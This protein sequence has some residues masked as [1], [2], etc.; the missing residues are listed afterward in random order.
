MLDLNPAALELD[1]R[2]R[3]FMAKFYELI[4]TPRAAKR[5]VNVY[6]LIRASITNPHELMWFLQGREFAAVQVL[7]AIVTGAPAES[8]EILR[9]LLAVPV[10]GAWNTNW[11]VLVDA[12]AKPRLERAG[13]QWL[14]SRLEPLRGDVEVPQTCEGFRKWADDVARYSFYSGRVLLEPP[15]EPFGAQP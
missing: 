4:P 7:L 1:E 6:R 8:S 11:W 13:W 10:K 2:E 9:E 15:R 12:V 14:H 5:F 3:L